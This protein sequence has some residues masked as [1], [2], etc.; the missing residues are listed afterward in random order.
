M[1]PR[2]FV[3]SSVEALD[4]AYTIQENL[5]F[6]ATVTVWNQGVFNLSNTALDDLISALDNFD[7]GIFVFK[8]DDVTYIRSEKKN[9]IRDNVIFEL[10]LFIGRLGKDK[11]F[12]LTPRNSPPF[13]I[14]TDLLGITA[15]TFDVKRED[16]NIKA[17][18]GPFCNQIRAR[19]KN[20]VYSNLSVL[21][22]ESTECK[23]L[24][25][26][27]PNCWNYLLA[28]ELLSNKLMEIHQGY[29]DLEK[30]HIFQ[31]AKI[32]NAEEYFIWFQEAIEDM[33]RFTTLIPE[34]ID[35]LNNSVVISDEGDRI[36]NIKKSVDR[37]LN[38]CRELVKWE[39]LRMEIEPPR[40]LAEVKT[41]AKGWSKTYFNSINSLPLEIKRKIEVEKSPENNGDSKFI[42]VDSLKGIDKA[43]NIFAEYFATL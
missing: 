28:A 4:I 39:Y 2:I 38:F 29:I 32:Y 37:I 36:S 19:L 42:N 35:D 16:N 27:K 3:G 26:E 33:K 34:L 18:L 31:K 40:E 43:I 41:I 30:G 5:E 13:H 9:T 8:P 12:Y 23:R 11:V 7:F 20:F 25:I 14:P 15:G 24:A 10:G 17:A 6:D 22:E 1:K 21:R